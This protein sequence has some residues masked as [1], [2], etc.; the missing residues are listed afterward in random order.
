VVPSTDNIPLKASSHRTQARPCRQTCLNCASGCAAP[1]CAQS[2]CKIPKAGL[3]IGPSMTSRISSNS[4][5][6]RG[7]RNM[8]RLLSMRAC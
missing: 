8:L 7:R 5:F 4:S 3:P 1:H 2:L 6:R